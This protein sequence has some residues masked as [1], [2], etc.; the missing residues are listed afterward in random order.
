[1]LQLEELAG[2][3][4]E[5]RQRGY[6]IGTQEC[7]NAHR[8]FLALAA[9]GRAPH[10][11]GAL[12]TLL[13]PLFCSTPVEQDDFHAWFSGWLNRQRLSGQQEAGP[14]PTPAPAPNGYKSLPRLRYVLAAIVIVAVAVVG[15]RYFFSAPDD[16]KP[17][18][19]PTVTPTP[20]VTPPT[21]RVTTPTPTPTHPDSPWQSL[22]WLVSVLPLLFFVLFL[23][24][25]FKSRRLRQVLKRTQTD[26]PPE[27]RHVPVAGIVD[28]LFQ[29]SQTRRIAQEMHRY[30]ENGDTGTRPR[31][32]CRGNRQQ[33][34]RVHRRVRRTQG[35]ARIP[36]PGRPR[37]LPRSPSM[38]GG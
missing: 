22:D 11:A 30:R 32:H 35:A 3:V 9:E 6:D 37:Q 19:T 1:M 26:R 29:P 31:G 28:T 2:L 14:C 7:L 27:L 15:W 36:C 8:L 16:S 21:P 4:E 18:S 12:T 24:W 13:A 10:D 25:L 5:L 38:L 33:R 20:R 23:V 34:R 17:T